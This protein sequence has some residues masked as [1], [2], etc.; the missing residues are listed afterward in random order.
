MARNR[1]LATEKA[2]ADQL[3]QKL[4]ELMDERAGLERA[5]AAYRGGAVP[6]GIKADLET[7]DSRTTATAGPFTA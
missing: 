4:K 5:K 1:A 7:N 6:D 3:A 2:R